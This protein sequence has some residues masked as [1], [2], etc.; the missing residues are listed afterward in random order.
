[1]GG[2]PLGSF[3]FPFSSVYTR[4]SGSVLESRVEAR[5]SMCH[6]IVTKHI[7]DPAG[8][9]KFTGDLGKGETYVHIMYMSR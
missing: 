3:T 7:K 9:K 4:L 5:G 1:M 8:L 6:Y 2:I